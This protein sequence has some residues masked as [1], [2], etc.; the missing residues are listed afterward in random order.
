M[1]DSI[2]ETNLMLCAVLGVKDTE[3]VTGVDLKIRPNEFPRVVVTRIVKNADGFRDA[4]E[5]FRLTPNKDAE[6][7]GAGT[8]RA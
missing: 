7:E 8:P 2:K 5:A 3:G 6:L 4:K 1:S